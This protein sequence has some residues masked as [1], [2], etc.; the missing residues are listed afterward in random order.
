MKKDKETKS[1]ELYVQLRSVNATELNNKVKFDE[2]LKAAKSNGV[3]LNQ[4]SLRTSF[5]LTHRIANSVTE[6][7]WLNFNLHGGV[8]T[9]KLSPAEMNIIT[10]G[11]VQ[12]VL[13]A[14]AGAFAGD[15]DG[16]LNDFGSGFSAGAS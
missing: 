13:G 16:S 2:V 7:E 8:P 11:W 3:D 9:V 12:F 5:A 10:G 14:L 15:V 4:E 1:K 6:D